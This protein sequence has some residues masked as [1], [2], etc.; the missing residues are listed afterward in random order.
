MN[1]FSKTTIS[2]L[3]LLLWI[4]L[5]PIISYAKEDRL[6]FGT[7]RMD[8]SEFGFLAVPDTTFI[9]EN[10]QPLLQE[11]EASGR[12]TSQTGGPHNEFEILFDGTNLNKWTGNTTDYV[13][14][15]GV[16]VIYPDRGGKGDLFTKEEFGDFLFEFE[17]QLTPGA[18]NG[19]GIRAPLEGS[20]A[21]DGIE[22]QIIDNTAEKYKNIEDYQR[23]GSVYGVIPAK[24]GFLKPVGEWNYQEVVVKGSRIKVVLNGTVILDGDFEAAS[25]NGTLDGK[26]H[27]GLKRKKGHI[28]FLGHGDVVRFKNIKVRDLG[29]EN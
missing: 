17:F 22:L 27:P 7:L 29:G 5:P 15:D 12:D 13:V 10:D 16:L 14:E 9:H 25:K 28:G 2:L 24:T 20:A 4:M 26:E 6:V 19:L 1:F 18:N 21:F 8:S 23:H 3:N 11:L